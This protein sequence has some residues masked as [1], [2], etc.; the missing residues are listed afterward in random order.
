[1]SAA[2]VFSSRLCDPT[3]FSP[4]LQAVYPHSDWTLPDE[5]AREGAFWWFWFWC[6]VA[7]LV[8][9]VFEL[10]LLAARLSKPTTLRIRL[11]AELPRF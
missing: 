9:M 10:S 5:G 1:M 4:P 7:T 3:P 6:L 11:Q 8:G 2:I